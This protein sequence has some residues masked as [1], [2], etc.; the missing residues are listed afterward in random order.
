MRAHRPDVA[1]GLRVIA[2]TAPTPGLPLIARGRG[3][4]E[5]ARIEAVAAGIA[6]T[7]APVRRALGLAGLVRTA[8]EAYDLLARR[9]AAAR[10]LSVAHGL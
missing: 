10:A 3:A 8:P 1:A 5:P 6:A 2:R 7:P 4:A 9:D